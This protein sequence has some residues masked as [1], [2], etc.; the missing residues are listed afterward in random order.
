MYWVDLGPNYFIIDEMA[1]QQIIMEG[2]GHQRDSLGAG[3]KLMFGLFF[4]FLD[5]PNKQTFK[6]MALSFY[7]ISIY[8]YS[9]CNALT[10]KA[11][12]EQSPIMS[13]SIFSKE[14]KERPGSCSYVYHSML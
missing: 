6:T 10:L 3:Q 7:F 13:Y 4:F 8:F 11:S 9:I 2:R 1:H 5:G 12:K 14:S